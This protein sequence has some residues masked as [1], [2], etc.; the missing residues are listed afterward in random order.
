[1]STL[2]QKDLAL[3]IV[4]AFLSMMLSIFLSKALISGPKNKDVKVEVVEPISADFPEPDKRF[5]NEESVNP[6]QL[7]RIEENA[8]QSPFNT[9]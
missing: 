3:I 7:I 2:K 5:F 4:I 6:T 1:M 8:N 9:N